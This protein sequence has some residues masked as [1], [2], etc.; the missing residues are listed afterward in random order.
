[1]SM[2][3]ITALSPNGRRAYDVDVASVTKA[4][5]LKGLH[6][7]DARAKTVLDEMSALTPSQVHYLIQEGMDDLGSAELERRST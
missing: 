1:M 6:V 3:T 7:V 2:S 4:L 5:E